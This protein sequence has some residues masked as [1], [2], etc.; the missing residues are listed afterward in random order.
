LDR[1][2]VFQEKAQEGWRG[3]VFDAP[4]EHGQLFEREQLEENK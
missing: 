4:S 3:I 2:E 1:Q